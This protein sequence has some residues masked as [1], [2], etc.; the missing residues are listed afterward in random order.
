LGIII[1]RGDDRRTGKRLDIII[2]IDVLLAAAAL[3]V[4]FADQYAIDATLR[5]HDCAVRTAALLGEGET[6]VSRRARVVRLPAVPG[7]HAERDARV[8]SQETHRRDHGKHRGGGQ[9]PGK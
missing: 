6:H 8:E 9:V 4:C 7:H 5:V 1:V 3:R 2:I